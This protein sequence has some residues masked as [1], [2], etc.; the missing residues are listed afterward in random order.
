MRTFRF[1]IAG[2]LGVITV[3]GI[4]LAA[5][6]EA[7]EFW[8]SGLFTL[9]LGVLLVSVLLAIHR[10]E[11]RRA[12][13]GGFA[14]FGWGYMALSLVP[15]IEP[16]LVTTK[17]LAY[18][19]AQVPGR[20]LGFTIRLSELGPGTST[21]HVQGLAFSPDGSRIATANRGGRVGLWDAAT[22]RLL[23]TVA[24]TDENF[25]RIGHSLFALLAGGAGGLVSRR[26]WRSP[27]SARDS[28]TV[29]AQPS[30]L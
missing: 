1:T 30:G 7:S 16:R 14:L 20:A 12:F 3:L 29:E 5:L 2:L 11:D 15:S 10:R 22:G 18:L 9:T 26:L 21:K 6:R 25:V 19:D 17:A 27:G 23:G 4:G 24:G 13:W 8:D 28:R